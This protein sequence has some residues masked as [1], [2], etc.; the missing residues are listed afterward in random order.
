MRD[1]RRRHSAYI[2]DVKVTSEFRAKRYFSNGTVQAQRYAARSDIDFDRKDVSAV[3][4][5]IGPQ[6]GREFL[7]GERT[8]HRVSHIDDDAVQLFA[9]EQQQLGLGVTFHGLVVIKVIP[10]QIG[11]QR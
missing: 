7:A 10:A 8:P 2:G 3:I 9:P 5:T 1:K 6:P 4:L 11:K